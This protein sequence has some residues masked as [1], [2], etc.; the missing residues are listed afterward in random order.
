MIKTAC[1]EC[2]GYDASLR[3]QGFT[4]DPQSGRELCTLCDECVIMVPARDLMDLNTEEQVD[5][6]L[7][8]W[9]KAT[10]TDR[11]WTLLLDTLDVSD[12]TVVDEDA[13][14]V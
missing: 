9:V 7:K 8:A 14:S 13:D 12:Q 4:H 2:Q 10:N 5:R 1:P 6:T 11:A 3:S